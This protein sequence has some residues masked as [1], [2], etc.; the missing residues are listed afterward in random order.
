MM[1]EEM[2]EMQ[3][4]PGTRA[5]RKLREAKVDNEG[6]MGPIREMVKGVMG[7]VGSVLGPMQDRLQGRPGRSED[8]M[9]ELAREIAR[10]RGMKSGGKVGSASKRADGCAVK[11]KTRGRMV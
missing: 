9:S 6:G 8:E 1:A 4:R 2:E 7:G 5:M 10:G 3:A 11:G